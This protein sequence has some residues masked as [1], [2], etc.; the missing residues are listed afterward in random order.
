MRRTAAEA[1]RTREALIVAGVAHFAEH[2]YAGADLQSIADE[3][4][5][6]RGAIYHHFGSKRGYF[7]AVVERA[8]GDLR[9]RIVSAA[10]ER[11]DPWDGL[12]AG[13][14]AFLAAAV[15]PTFRRIGLLDGPAVLGWEA[16]RAIDERTTAGSLGEGL[17]DLA[18]RGALSTR[19]VEALTLALSGAMNELSLWIASQPDSAAAL[20]RARDT[21]RG[22]LDAYRVS[23][24][25][26][27]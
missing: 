25:S 24:A 17:A 3:A 23:I 15:D 26:G 14:D 13:C 21:V 8:F 9:A 27:T 6:T 18:M 5:V 22:L 19:D 4:G 7:A 11:R 2:A 10:D 16:W 1:A 12:A 20:A